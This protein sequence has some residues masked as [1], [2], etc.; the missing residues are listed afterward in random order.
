MG[1]NNS[2]KLLWKASGLTIQD[3]LFLHEKKS[4]PTDGSKCRIDVDVSIVMA[5]SGQK[6]YR[7]SLLHTA[8][9]LKS[10][11][12][13]CGIIVTVILDG[14]S[15][16]DCKRDTWNRRCNAD[17]AKVNAF[18]CRK[19]AISLALTCN[20]DGAT[21]EDKKR[22]R[23]FNDA[24]KTLENASHKMTIPSHFKA[25]LEDRLMQLGA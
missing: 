4:N 9:Y 14:N 5:S 3:L 7:D 1:I 23:L 16:P 12:H 20:S 11:A 18:F 2:T 13:S 10:V 8:T 6:N 15:R 21:N 17:L 25:N 24:A 22:L 19:N